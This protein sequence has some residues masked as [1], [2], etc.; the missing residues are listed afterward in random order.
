MEQLGMLEELDRVDG[1]SQTALKATLSD[2]LINPE[3]FSTQALH[4]LFDESAT[5]RLLNDPKKGSLDRWY[6]AFEK[7]YEQQMTIQK[8]LF[9]RNHSSGGRVI[10]Y[11]ISS[12]YFE[13]THCPLAAYGYNRDGKKGK[14]QVVFGVITDEKGQPI[15]IKVFKGNTKDETTVIDQLNELRRDFELKEVIF[16]GDRGMITSHHLKTLE[17]NEYEDWLRYITAIKRSDMMKLVEDESHPIQLG[18]FDKDQLV[19][20]CENGKR[21]VLCHNPLKKEEDSISRKRL[22]DK[23]E[24]KLSSLKTQ[25]MT[26]RLKAKDKIAKRLYSWINK[27]NMGR[28][29]EVTYGQADFNYTIKKEEVTRYEVLDG[30]YVI[31]SNLEK[32]QATTKELALRYKSLAYVEQVFRTMK[33]TD[34]HVRPIRKWNEKRVQ[35]YLFI[36]MLAYLIVWKARQNLSEFLVRD[37]KTNECKGGSLKEIW[38][39]L[40][41]VQLGRLRFGSIVKEKMSSIG[42]YQKQLL[43]ALGA[44]ITPS[45]ISGLSLRK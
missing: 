21:Y 19:E 6:I 43:H 1:I 2:R 16:V 31:T 20:V 41:S 42:L 9:K 33:T 24:T 37:P 10:L 14:V 27:W 7:I 45:S 32:D 11:D 22:M 26:G 28:F 40:K 35:G 30:C 3:P 13:G 23:T 25:V 5:K 12:S 17:T 15:A 34:I 4:R 36:C 18:L 29:F 8:S 44:D 38:E 39:S